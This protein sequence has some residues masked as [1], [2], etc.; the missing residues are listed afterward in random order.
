M[1]PHRQALRALALVAASRH[2]RPAVLQGAKDLYALEYPV[3]FE[4][5]LAT[6]VF[7]CLPPAIETFYKTTDFS[8]VA[9][10][11]PLF[12]A[13]A[14][15][16]VSKYIVVGAS[17][18]EVLF[19]PGVAKLRTVKTM[20][21]FIETC[22]FAGISIEIITS[23]LR[24]MF[25]MPIEEGDIREFVRLFADRE[26][27]DA[28]GWADYVVCISESEATLKVQLR[29]QPHEYVRWRLGVPVVPN[30]EA[31]LDRM[32]ADAYFTERVMKSEA[33]NNGISM[34]KDELAR[35]KM[36]RDTIFKAVNLKMKLKETGGGSEANDAKNA[37]ANIIAKYDTSLV[38]LMK[39]VTGVDPGASG[40]DAPPTPPPMPV[41]PK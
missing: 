15:L 33:G 22:V 24:T 16:G 14:E 25:G 35:I 37:L 10:Y 17:G 36:D 40:A 4:A 1:V 8:V 5:F 32:I 23:D 29:N 27:L 20:R 21:V 9:D 3:P 11:R 19:P 38:P 34:G 18:P 30:A 13:A 12:A 41:P 6:D 26:W 39:D 31:I 2:D 28:G 7:G